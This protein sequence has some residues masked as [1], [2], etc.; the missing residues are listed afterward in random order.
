MKVSENGSRTF[1]INPLAFNSLR[2]ET[3]SPSQN[4]GPERTD[5]QA[6]DLDRADGRPPESLD[7]MSDRL[8]QASDQAIAP[9]GQHDL[10]PAIRYVLAVADRRIAGPEIPR[11]RDQARREGARR[12]VL[13]PDAALEPAQLRLEPGTATTLRAQLGRALQRYNQSSGGALLVGA[14]DLLAS[15]SVNAVATDLGEG[16]WNASDNPTARTLSG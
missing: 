5:R 6:P 12:A 14:A 15:T 2:S 11:F 7:R 4:G 13:E 3:R 8:E 10:D 16:Y 9:L 1:R